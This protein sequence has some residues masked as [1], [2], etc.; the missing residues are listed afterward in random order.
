[1]R[2]PTQAFGAG[3]TGERP[4]SWRISPRSGS[5]PSRTIPQTAYGLSPPA[6]GISGARG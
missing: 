1:M 3:E 4:R 2:R 5:T 6:G